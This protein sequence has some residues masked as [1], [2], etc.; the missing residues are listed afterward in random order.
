MPITRSY[1]RWTTNLYTIE[2]PATLTKLCY[3][4]RE[5]HNVLKMSTID[6]NARWVIAP[7]SLWHN[8]G[9]VGDN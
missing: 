6:R 1:L 7:N 5:H 4:K 2:L 9:T 3:I 8:F